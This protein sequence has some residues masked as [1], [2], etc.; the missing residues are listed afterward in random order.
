MIGKMLEANLLSDPY[1][2]YCLG[3]HVEECYNGIV[4]SSH[5]I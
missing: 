5:G 4:G 1:T 2:G 3:V